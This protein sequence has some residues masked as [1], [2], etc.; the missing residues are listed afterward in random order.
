[1]ISKNSGG[2]GLSIHNIRATGS[3]IRGTNG[4]SNGLIPLLRVF[5]SSARFVS[6]G[7]GKRNGSIA[8]YLEPWHADIGIFLDLKKNHG[9]EELRARDLFYALWVPDLFMERVETDSDW[10]LFCPN[11]APGLGDCWGEEFN[12][13]YQKYE[14]AGKARSRV[15]ARA[16]WQSIVKAQ[17]ETGTPY[18]LFKD[19]CNR[20]SNQQNLGT[21]R[22]SNL[23]TEIIEYSSPEETAV[24]NLASISLPLMVVDGKFNFD[25]LCDVVRMITLSLNRVIDRNFYPIKEAATSNLRHRP[26]GIGVQGLA[27]LF[28]ILRL[29]FESAAAA[30]LNRDIFE[31]IYFAALTESCRL[32]KEEGAYESYKG[33]PVSKGASVLPSVRVISRV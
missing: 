29:P 9:A 32:A 1:M 33:S 24:C 10:S 7:G 26:I 2:I 13:L 8:I 4:V 31:T 25:R 15:K 19:A 20:K 22:S 27:D 12:A 21:I 6:Q 30:Q 3:Y 23:C 17:M 18:L 11:E 5:N 28:M 16:L 14:A